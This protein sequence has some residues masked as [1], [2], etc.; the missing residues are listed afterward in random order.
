MSP[1][2]DKDD[3]IYASDGTCS[4]HAIHATNF[5]QHNQQRWCCACCRRLYTSAGSF[6]FHPVSSAFVGLS[7]QDKSC[8]CPNTVCIPKL[9]HQVHGLKQHAWSSET[10]DVLRLPKTLCMNNYHCICVVKYCIWTVARCA[11]ARFAFRHHATYFHGNS[12]DAT[13][14]G[15]SWFKSFGFLFNVTDFAGTSFPQD[16]LGKHVLEPHQLPEFSLCLYKHVERCTQ[17]GALLSC[18]EYATLFV[19]LNLMQVAN[20][21][22]NSWQYCEEF[23]TWRKQMFFLQKYIIF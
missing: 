9:V 14:D 12:V 8:A 1:C 6:R 7:S 13:V 15:C 5:A 18:H 11:N 10:M 17:T 21:L 20:P 22:L 23:C 19:K 16:V 4:I 3:P 2:T